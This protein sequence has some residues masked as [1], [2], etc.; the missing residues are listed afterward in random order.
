MFTLKAFSHTCFPTVKCAYLGGDEELPVDDVDV[1]NMTLRRMFT[2]MKMSGYRPTC[3][4]VHDEGGRVFYQASRGAHY[5]VKLVRKH[6]QRLSTVKHDD[7]EVQASMREVMVRMKER[8]SGLMGTMMNSTN[9]DDQLSAVNDDQTMLC[10]ALKNLVDHV[11]NKQA[12]IVID[13]DKNERL[14]TGAQKISSKEQ[15]RLAQEAAAKL[16]KIREETE[17]M[18]AAEKQQQERDMAA[19]V[20]LSALKV[21]LVLPS[22]LCGF[23]I[24]CVCVCAGEAPGAGREGERPS[25][26]GSHG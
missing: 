4:S 21:R 24:V 19:R 12:K 7:E 3:S 15:E 26:S 17:K 5:Q 18:A 1:Q 25:H 9:L 13:Y 11:E 16:S 22:L 10:N 20:R 6:M 2:V 8:F 23:L 14:K